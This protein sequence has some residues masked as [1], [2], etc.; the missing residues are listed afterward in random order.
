MAAPMSPPI[1]LPTHYDPSFKVDIQLHEPLLSR[2][3]TLGDV[4]LEMISLCFQLETLCKKEIAEQT[5]I[6]HGHVSNSFIDRAT[7]VLD[8]MTR[9]LEKVPPEFQDCLR[10]IYSQ[11][12]DK[13]FPRAVTYLASPRT[14]ALDNEN[15]S[16]DNYL[17]SVSQLGQMST[18]ARQLHNDCANPSSHKYIAHQLALLYQTLTSLKSP[19]FSQHKQSIEGM[20]KPIKATLAESD[21]DMRRCLT[22]E[23]QEWLLNLTSHILNILNTFPAELTMDMVLPATVLLKNTSP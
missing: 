6:R 20:F 1:V 7:V 22:E 19:V 8:R 16:L 9:L 23:Q 12:L 13:L 10:Y 15:S 4:R 17:N 5:S 2:A 21:E 11:G 14:F 18:L 3:V